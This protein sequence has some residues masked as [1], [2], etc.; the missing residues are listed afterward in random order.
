[1]PKCVIDILIVEPFTWHSVVSLFNCPRHPLPESLVYALQKKKNERQH[2]FL[3]KLTSRLKQGASYQYY[4]TRR[5]CQSVSQ[6]SQWCVPSLGSLSCAV[7]LPP[8]KKSPG[9]ALPAISIQSAGAERL[10]WPFC[11]PRERRWRGGRRTRRLVWRMPL[12][13]SRLLLSPRL[14]GVIRNRAVWR[15]V[16]LE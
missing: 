6:S 4:K 8:V 14:T 10:K 9:R 5:C 16:L 11:P 3:Q 1:M 12:S 13:P 15:D 2:Y 7:N